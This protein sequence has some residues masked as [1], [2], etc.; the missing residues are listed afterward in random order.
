MLQVGIVGLPNVGKSTVFNAL[1]QGGA[2][3]SNYAFCTV[4]PNRAVVG[5]PDARLEAVARIF[6][7]AQMVP[8]SIQFVDIAGLVRG[9][10]KGEGLGNQFLAAIREVD[11]V[12]HVVRCFKDDQVSHVE[13]TIDPVRDVEIVEAELALA[14]L[15]AVERRQEKIA[16]ALKGRLAAAVREAQALSALSAHL[17]SSRPARTIANREETLSACE[18][19][20][21]T[22]KPVIYLANVGEE[23]GQSAL[24]VDRL[25]ASVPGSVVSLSARL[26]ADL[27]E[28]E[29]AE[30]ADFVAE[31]GLTTSGLE[32]VIRACY[33]ALDLVTFFTGVGAEARAWAAPRGTTAAQA[34]AGIHSDMER[35]FI[36]AELI[37]YEML[38]ELGSWQDAHRTGKVRTEGRDYVI[39]EGDVLLVRFSA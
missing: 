1:C 31:L 23:E 30:R 35:R 19:F 32:R 20:L 33:E 27:A 39:Q 17:Q 34:A 28:L 18:L 11:A 4:E 36:R 13:G 21:L 8:A 25:S 3:V 29:D 38:A 16:S 24:Y 15:G 37:A 9:A 2:K 10:S 26:Q 7:Q 14:D 5:V 22:D 6:E 12:L